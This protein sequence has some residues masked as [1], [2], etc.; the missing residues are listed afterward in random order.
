VG[1][2]NSWSLISKKHWQTR[3]Y[4]MLIRFRFSK[5]RYMT[6]SSLLVSVGGT[7]DSWVWA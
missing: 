2:A 3:S 1:L 5:L 6:F 4:D 7:P